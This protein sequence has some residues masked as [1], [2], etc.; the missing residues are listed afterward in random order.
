MIKVKRF[1]RNTAIYLI[2]QCAC[3][4][5]DGKK[6][7]GI[8]CNRCGTLV[9]TKRTVLVPNEKLYDTNKIA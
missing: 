8:V 9:W 1:K 4:K 3:G 6:F 5:F 2:W 7:G